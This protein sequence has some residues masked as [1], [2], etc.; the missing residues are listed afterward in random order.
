MSFVLRFFNE[1][2][3]SLPLKIG[4]LQIGTLSVHVSAKDLNQNFSRQTMSVR[5]LAVDTMQAN[6]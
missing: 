6:C 4:T 1:I 3:T 5:R 2:F